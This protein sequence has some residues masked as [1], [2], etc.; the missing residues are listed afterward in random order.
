ML[1]YLVSGAKPVVWQYRSQYTI[2]SPS[3]VWQFFHLGRYSHICYVTNFSLV[4]LTQQAVMFII[5]RK[6]LFWQIDKQFL[7]NSVL[8]LFFI[9]LLKS[10]HIL[11]PWSMTLFWYS[12]IQ[13]SC[14][15][16]KEWEAESSF[17]VSLKIIFLN[18]CEYY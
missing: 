7:Q 3:L 4:S 6:I 9:K 14:F 18:Y 16:L 13:F 5:L 15:L 11:P 10:V 8:G 17:A 2:D 12:I 1:F